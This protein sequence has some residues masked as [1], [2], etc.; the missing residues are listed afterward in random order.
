[1]ALDALR[2]TFR[3]SGPPADAE[4]AVDDAV[5]G[6]S[7]PSIQPAAVS[8][9]DVPAAYDPYAA[10]VEPADPLPDTRPFEPDP[11]SPPAS[12]SSGWMVPPVTPDATWSTYQ[13]TQFKPVYGDPVADDATDGL[14]YPCPTCAR[15]IAHG[16]RRCEGCG[17]RLL[18]DVP[19][20]RAATL[21]G[22]GAVAGI[23]A[24]LLVVN[25]FAPARVA[26]L[27]GSGVV[28]TPSGVASSGDA[29][30]VAIPASAAAALQ[31]TTEING[32]LA[33]EA[34]PLA[35]ALAA[36]SFKTG[37]VVKVLR[38]MAVNTRAG[39][40]MLRPMGDWA[41]A[42]DQRAALASFYDTLDRQIQA[43]LS[44]SVRSRTAYKKAAKQV[45]ATLRNAPGL[46]A[47]ARELVSG[48]GVQL[49]PV[50][51]PVALR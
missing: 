51:F 2:S 38:R 21:S 11:L 28:P 42:A 23:V 7:V 1:M 22:A 24:T 17:E 5:P 19:M 50:T 48:A 13:P 8:W 41:S 3:R 14:G 34:G 45:L 26:V 29:A 39:T 6:L 15:T 27:G 36:K 43:G 20:R 12:P 30:L 18:L 16:T 32:R 47:A 31:G 9:P 37:P 10:L 4:S 44:A 25:L 46:D 40:G 35:K 49:P 33:S